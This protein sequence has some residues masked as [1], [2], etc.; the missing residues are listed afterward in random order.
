LELLEQ[1]HALVEHAWC[2]G[3]D[4]RDRDGRPVDPWAPEA[5]C[6]S[7]LGAI[8]AVL[9][10][11]A[12]RIGEIPLDQLAAALYALSELID[13]DSLVAWNDHPGR[14]Q[15]EV[16]EVLACAAESYEAGLAVVHVS[17]N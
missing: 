12:S 1:A 6:W 16:A 15:R 14:S 2:Q 9:E 5:A 4:A 7:L 8:V 11:E 3:A 13:T 17:S 10:S